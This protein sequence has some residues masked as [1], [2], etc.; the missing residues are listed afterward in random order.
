MSPSRCPRALLLA[1]ALA[2]LLAA[3]AAASW[4]QPADGTGLA[5]EIQGNTVRVRSE[6]GERAL[7]LRRGERLTAA[8]ELAGGWVA[9]GTRVTGEEQDLVV[10]AAE[11]GP[12][13]R[14]PVPGAT[15]ATFWRTRPVLLAGSGRLEGLAWLEGPPRGPFAVR[16]A[17]LE[18]GG[19]GLP[20]TVA[21][22]TAGSQSGLAGTV[23]ADGTW[24]LVWARFDGADDDL[25]WSVGRSDGWTPPAPVA[26][27]NAVPDVTPSLFPLP[28]GALVAWG[29]LVDGQY[30]V[31]TARLGE[32]GWGAARAVTGPGT[33]YPGFAGRAGTPY[34]LART[35]LP[36]GWLV[37][38]LDAEG[39]P[40]RRAAVA[41][42][43]AAERP[44][45]R[46]AA[47]RPPS[48]AFRPGAEA[49]LVWESVP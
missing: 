44:G 3:T 45:V 7:R 1:G 39:R 10:L 25:V 47:D 5:L 28:D 37:L 49:P 20:T 4:V 30:R 38:E 48:L 21:L 6:A 27:D 15:T 9:A 18:A 43:R 24:L 17:H 31:L 22:P 35:A 32:N 40:L 26:P 33:V 14:L 2:A 13:R 8:A 19:W 41:G 11:G 23:L 36:A 34:L 42:G 29:R 12:V 16:A 46:L